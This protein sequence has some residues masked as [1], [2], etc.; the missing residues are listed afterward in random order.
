MALIL[1][2]NVMVG[3]YINNSLRITT[4]CWCSQATRQKSLGLL[5]QVAKIVASQVAA[6]S[7]TV[8]ALE[9]T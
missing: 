4:Q 7:V 8:S 6:K 1:H 5:Q 3:S 2:E 9:L